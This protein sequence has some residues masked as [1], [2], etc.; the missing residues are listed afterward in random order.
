MKGIRLTLSRGNKVPLPQCYNPQ[1]KRRQAKYANRRYGGLSDREL[2]PIIA[3]EISKKGQKIGL[4]SSTQVWR[5][6]EPVA[7]KIFS[8]H[9]LDKQRMM[10]YNTIQ[11]AQIFFGDSFRP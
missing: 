3:W 7:S 4:S 9:P 11:T 6:R 2:R 1:K 10:C 5:F 8:V